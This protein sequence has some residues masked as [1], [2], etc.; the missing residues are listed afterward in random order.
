MRHLWRL[1][2]AFFHGVFASEELIFIARNVLRDSY[3]LN[4]S[5]SF[6]ED[7]DSLGIVGVVDNDGA[8][9]PGDR[10]GVE[11]LATAIGS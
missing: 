11:S 3:F 2:E 9:S 7:L 1:Y 5:T 8:F 6:G 10:S 4:E